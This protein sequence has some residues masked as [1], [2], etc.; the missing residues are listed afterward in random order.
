VA[1]VEPR[2][3]AIHT[4]DAEVLIVAFGTAA[5]F[6]E[7]VVGEMREEGHKVGLFRPITLWPFPE[8]ALEQAAASA[9]VV[10]VFEL[11]AGQMID[12]V[13]ISVPNRRLVRAIGGISTDRSGLSIGDL[14]DA[15]VV[16]ARIESLMTG[17]NA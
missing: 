7:Y 4:N 5:K 17:V 14:L 15:P 10:G 12:D 13:K 1:Q 11:N 6:V 3:E 16:R 9:K 8:E 2:W